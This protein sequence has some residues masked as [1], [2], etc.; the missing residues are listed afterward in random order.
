[1]P[2]LISMTFSFA[3]SHALLYRKK[4]VATSGPAGCLDL[5]VRKRAAQGAAQATTQEG[6]RLRCT[7]SCQ[8]LRTAGAISLAYRAADSSIHF[9]RLFAPPLR[10]RLDSTST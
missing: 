6:G 8:T 2:T 9:V 5:P 1:M 4:W 7:R 10:A 3:P